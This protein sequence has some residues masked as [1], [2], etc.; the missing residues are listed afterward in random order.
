M[1]FS[2]LFCSSCTFGQVRVVLEKLVGLEVSHIV[3]SAGTSTDRP[4]ERN[5]FLKSPS[6]V[7]FYSRFLYPLCSLGRDIFSSE[8]SALLRKDPSKTPF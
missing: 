4:R 1:S 3:S 8:I 5:D 7:V 2:F 6:R